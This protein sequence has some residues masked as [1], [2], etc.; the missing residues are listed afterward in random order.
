MAEAP[1]IAVLPM[2]DQAGGSDRGFLA[3]GLTE[4]LT[5]SLSR[6]PGFIVIGCGALPTHRVRRDDPIGM[7]RELGVRYL[8]D[9]SVRRADGR[10][11]VVAQLIDAQSGGL[12]WAERYDRDVTALFEIQDDI[13]LNLVGRLGPEL[14]AAEIR[15]AA[16]KPAQDLDTWEC[17][18]RALFHSS[19]QSDQ[20]TRAALGLLDQALQRVPDHAA[21]LGMQAWIL[22]F[23]AFQGWEDMGDVLDRVQ[24][25]IARALAVDN[26]ELWPSLAQAMVGFATRDNVLSVTVLERAIALSPSSVN[27]HGL[28][29]VAH[30]FGGRF[31]PA[32]QSIG[33]AM[34]LSPRDTYLSDFELYNAFAH[35]QG[36]SYEAGLEYAQQAHRRRPGHAYPLVM[37]A[38]CA[39]HLRRGD[40]GGR[41]VGQLLSLAPDIGTGWVE[42]TSPYVLEADR[43]RLVQG[44]AQAGLGPGRP[45]PRSA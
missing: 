24:P 22:V 30:A 16:R 18:V 33:R 11:R 6:L 44:L 12:L 43:A 42:M 19:Q 4:D 7:G 23:R 5:A 13:T 38:S 45:P 28:L 20:E 3:A 26:R 37:A 34:R 40:L 31:E 14:L 39:G 2:L 35:F 9:G 41:L 1:A 36:A 29:G 32:V 25:R 15:R 10:L 21:A 27:A 8:L 17:V